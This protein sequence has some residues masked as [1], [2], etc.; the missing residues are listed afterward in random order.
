MKRKMNQCPKKWK[1]VKYRTQRLTRETEKTLQMETSLVN[2]SSQPEH[3][4]L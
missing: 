3:V 1:L 4:Q 2:Q